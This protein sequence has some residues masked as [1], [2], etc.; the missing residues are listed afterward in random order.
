MVTCTLTNEEKDPIE[1]QVC[2]EEQ[3]K[4][5]TVAARANAV[6]EFTTFFTEP[7]LYALSFTASSS[8]FEKRSYVSVEVV[9][10]STLSL[11]TVNAP[12]SLAYDE[13]GTIAFSLAHESGPP[14]RNV[15]V[16]LANARTH[17]DWTFSALESEQRFSVTTTGH[18]LSMKDDLF[19]LTVTYRDERGEENV[20]TQTFTIPLRDLKWWQRI[21]LAVQDWFS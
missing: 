4:D 2:L 9:G 21:L 16:T 19:T 5:I 11:S 10:K 15:T 18:A 6:A 12:A 1:A 17:Q 14:A 8:R 7:S 20:L 3:C 13:E